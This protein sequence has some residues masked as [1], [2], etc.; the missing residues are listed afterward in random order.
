[1]RIGSADAPRSA[2]D[3]SAA[4]HDQPWGLA[5]LHVAGLWTV[6]V[7]Q[8]IF[9]V[10]SRS[11]EFFVAHDARPGDVLGLVIV[12]CLVCPAGWAAAL[13]LGRRLGARAHALAAGLAVGAL[14]AAIALAA[15]K[16]AAVWNRELSFGVAAVCGALAAAG[17]VRSA[18]MRLFAT[19]LSPAT[20]VA[21]AVFLMQP[22]IAPLLSAAGGAPA[23][24]RGVAFDN[25]PPVVV[26][27][28]D[29]L[30]LVSLLDREGGI[31]RALYPNFA[32]LA[33]DATWFRNASG[34]SG[35]TQFALP[36][37]VTGNYPAPG[38]LPAV[39]DH[40]ANLFTL[41]GS[42]YRLHVREPLTGL[43]PETLCPP[44]RPGAGGWL[45]AV[46]GDLSV[47]YLQVVLPDDVAAALPPVTHSWRDFAD[48][49]LL[50]QWNASRRRDRRA[51]AVDFIS[52]IAPPTGVR[53]PLYFMH[54]LLPHEP[55]VYL[56]DGR[57]HTI[58]PHI[59][60]GV[61]DRWKDDAWAVTRE[62]QRHLLQVQY[63][64]TL[65]GALLERLRA[66]GAYDDALIVVTAD[67][68]ASLRPGR[69]FRMPTA[70]TF[71]DVA[72]VPLLVKRPGQ[73][74][75]RVSSANVETIDVLPT[76]AAEIGVRPPWDTDG[77]N[78]FDRNR[79]PRAAK[80]MFIHGARDR[81]H[82]PG[83]LGAAVA[84][85]VARKLEMFENGNPT[86][87]RLGVHDRL[88][89]ASVADLRSGRRAD[90]D[91]V[92]NDLALLR[93]LDPDADFVPAHITGGIVP[94][95]GGSVMPPLAVALNG[96]VAAVTRSYP[97]AAYGHAAPWE[98]IVDPAR[99]QPGSNAVGVFAIRT[100]PE[101]AAVLDEAIEVSSRPEPTNLVPEAAQR[102]LGVTSSGFL[103]SEST[104]HGDMRWTTGAAHLSAPIDPRF[105]P[106]ALAVRVLTTG[107]QKRLRIAVNGC[108]LFE[109]PVWGRWAE[110]L[111][112]DACPPDSPTLEI[113]VLSNVHEEL[114]AGRRLLGV[115]VSSIEL[116][117]GEPAQ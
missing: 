17:Y 48:D 45:A 52:S 92:V 95:V 110:T 19:F 40:P 36:A 16:Q 69:R 7:A 106:A 67:H 31:D 12:L 18:T 49:T 84:E 115:A 70:E 43:C 61:Q 23:A 101:G 60:A 90:V 71:A 22:A 79:T 88:V 51:A 113:E 114:G 32:A 1:M 15:V 29:Q 28:F 103:P 38:Q 87:P 82:G 81:L 93:N 30:P 78:A 53:P 26:A 57:R 59:M 96:V 21:P 65:L 37:I 58:R 117:E 97:F 72:G 4:F 27:V 54:V 47:V 109:G 85:G 25:P 116:L 68:G 33:D 83:D 76:L 10:L 2:L 75:G 11:P 8:P 100:G 20:L 99:L 86:A 112:L 102:V 62:Y 14:A 94:R 42:R 41:L 44:D 111:A 77:S 107:P 24:I 66:V 80:T 64:D 74:R 105:P 98:V 104:A 39:N 55:W 56:P 13:R 73:R 9:D 3:A 5:A 34:V 46:L 89:G 108:T 50:G 91:V 6:A 63:V 35:W